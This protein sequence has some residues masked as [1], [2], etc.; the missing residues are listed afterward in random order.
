MLRNQSYKAA[1][2][3]GAAS[4]LGLSLPASA[5]DIECYSSDEF[6][7]AATPYEAEAGTEFFVT[8][9]APSDTAPS[10]S[11]ATTGADFT[12]GQPSDP[13]WF[14]NLSGNFLVL[15]RSTGPDGDIVVYDL[16][17]PAMPVIDAPA[18]EI[19]V[20]EDGVTYWE[21]TGEADASS[22]PEYAENTANGFGSVTLSE[23]LFDFESGETSSSGTTKCGITQ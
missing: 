15:T 11:D 5:Q 23:T 3:L 19:S 20:T 8:T 13:L 10:C 22:C 17:S 4:L 7:V 21:V 14:E 18:Q 12:I 2:L 9:L 1:L 6:F 16:R